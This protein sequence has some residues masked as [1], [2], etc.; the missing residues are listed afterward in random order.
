M[1]NEMIGEL[2]MVREINEWNGTKANG[3]VV[4]SVPHMN[5]LKVK[6]RPL[7][8]YRDEEVYTYDIGMAVAEK[9]GVKLVINDTTT[10]PNK[11]D[12]FFDSDE[13]NRKEY[14]AALL[15]TKPQLVIDIHGSANVGP[16]FLSPRYDGIRYFRRMQEQTVIGQRPDVDI[17]YKRKHGN[18]TCKAKIVMQMAEVI[19]K[20][21][22]GVDFESVYPGGY[23]IEKCADIHTDAFAMEIVRNVREDL[24]KREKIIDAIS[25]FIK[26]YLH[27]SKLEEKVD[28]SDFTDTERIYQDYQNRFTNMR[29]GLSGTSV[30]GYQ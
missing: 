25:S 23:I 15:S 3:K 27:G 26:S 12:N 10:D 13:K 11:S 5:C 14:Y 7:K 19:A 2:R 20:K 21:G 9:T 29:G 8:V 4:I 22:F 18:T 24:A 17:E 6:F 16:L 30:L 28:L 1:S